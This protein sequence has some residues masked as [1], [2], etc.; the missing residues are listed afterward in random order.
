MPKHCLSRNLES[1]RVWP[2]RANPPKGHQWGA[3]EV[4]TTGLPDMG[5]VFL[6][7]PGGWYR[8]M[9]LADACVKPLSRFVGYRM[10][11]IATQLHLACLSQAKRPRAR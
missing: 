2:V 11:T 4:T 5:Q 1:T 8:A 6:E 7:I 9:A 3:A 10:A